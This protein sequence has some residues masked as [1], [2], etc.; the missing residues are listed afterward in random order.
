[1][2]RTCQVAARPGTVV[3]RHPADGK[4]Q[5]PVVDWR[6]LTLTPVGSE[7]PVNRTEVERVV[8]GSDARESPDRSVP[9]LDAADGTEVV[10]IY[11]GPSIVARG[12]GGMLH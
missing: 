2:V 4:P 11:P 7:T 3:E 9:V 5:L 12:P 6:D 10:G 8:I 1:Y